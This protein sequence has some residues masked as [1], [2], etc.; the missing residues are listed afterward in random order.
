MQKS[1]VTLSLLWQEYYFQC[2]A[3]GKLP[4]QPTQFNKHYADYVH[5]TKAT[6]HVDHKPGDTMQVD[7]AG[8]TGGII[9][10]DTGKII[11]VYMRSR[12]ASVQRLRIY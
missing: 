11:P 10:A 4:Y 12:C 9:D 8:Q 6:M 1:G 2:R 5:K 7:W 3:S